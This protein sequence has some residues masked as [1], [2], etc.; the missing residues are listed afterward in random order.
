[1]SAISNSPSPNKRTVPVGA[2]DNN[3]FYDPDFTIEI[4]NRMRV[5]DKI[6]VLPDSEIP[7]AD[8][9]DR[10]TTG[11]KGKGSGEWMHVPDRILVMGG[12]KHAAGH[13]PLP[14]MKLESSILGDDHYNG[15]AVVQMMTPPRNITLNDPNY[16]TIEEDDKT[17]GDGT[18]ILDYSS[19]PY[20]KNQKV[21]SYGGDLYGSPESNVNNSSYYAVESGS[22]DINFLR[23]QIKL[24]GRRISVLESENQQ[25]YHR[26]VI[27]CSLGVIYFILKGFSW[28]GRTSRW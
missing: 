27:L 7:L 22:A 1:M 18:H 12:N 28:F 4:S 2:Y 3:A 13:E 15:D 16:P 17:S 11:N 19:S 9:R 20:H 24:L 6:S 14:E 8:Q 21:G 26:E 23:R 10:L 5:P 25:R